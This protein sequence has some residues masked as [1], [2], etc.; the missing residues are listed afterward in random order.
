MKQLRLC[1][2]VETFPIRRKKVRV[3]V[4]LEVNSKTSLFNY[5]YG[6]HDIKL[7]FKQVLLIYFK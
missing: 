4:Q 7:L 1:K 3:S 2:S 5:R 6:L